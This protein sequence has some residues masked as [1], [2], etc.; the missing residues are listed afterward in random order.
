MRDL[1]KLYGDL[2]EFMELFIKILHEE[3]P[4]L[5]GWS[6]RGES[7]VICFI[8]WYKANSRKWQKRVRISKNEYDKIIHVISVALEMPEEIIKNINYETYRYYNF[9]NCN[10]LFIPELYVFWENEKC[11]STDRTKYMIKQYATRQKS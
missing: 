5:P 11:K 2:T 1:K 7:A 9:D 10:S 6:I 4:S 3:T 8:N